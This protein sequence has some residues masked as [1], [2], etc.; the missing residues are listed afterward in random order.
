MEVPSGLFRN[1]DLDESNWYA[2]KRKT[3][4]ILRDRGL[5]PYVTGDRRHRPREESDA[6]VWERY[7][8]KAQTILDLTIGTK[9][10][11][12]M[13]GANSAAEMWERLI[14]LKEPCGSLALVSVWRRCKAW[15][16]STL[17]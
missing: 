1:I 4:T 15:F 5:L 3:M 11:N 14:Q 2:W 16:A 17:C 7:D 10:I 9:S 6:V 12:H 13:V 8:E